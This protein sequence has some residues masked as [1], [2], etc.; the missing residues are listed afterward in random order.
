MLE[1]SD[2]ST[3]TFSYDS[4]VEGYG[5]AGGQ[6]TRLTQLKDLDGPAF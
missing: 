5:S 3:V 1:Y 6:Y 2:C 4:T